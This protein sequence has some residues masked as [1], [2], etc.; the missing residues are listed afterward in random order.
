MLRIETLGMKDG[1][2]YRCSAEGVVAMFTL[3]VVEPPTTANEEP[4]CDVIMTAHAV[5]ASTQHDECHCEA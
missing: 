4:V 2:V 3:V 1:G 5:C